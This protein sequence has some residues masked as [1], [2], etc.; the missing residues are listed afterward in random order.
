M[1]GAKSVL[2]KTLSSPQWAAL[3]AIRNQPYPHSLLAKEELI[4]N[5]RIGNKAFHQG[6]CECDKSITLQW[7]YKEDNSCQCGITKHHYHCPLC[8]GVTQIG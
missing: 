5:L 3:S 6:W 1:E 4:N 7:Y 2:L 8:G